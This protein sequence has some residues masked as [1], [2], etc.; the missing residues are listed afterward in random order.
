MIRALGREASVD[1]DQECETV[2]SCKTDEL[3]KKAAS[4]FI[5]H[6]QE[7]QGQNQQHQAAEQAQANNNYNGL[8]RVS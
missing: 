5:Q 7:M 3:S 6:L 8:R 4:A 1:T 2:M